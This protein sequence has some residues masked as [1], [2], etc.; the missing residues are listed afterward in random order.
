MKPGDR[1][2]DGGGG[3]AVQGSYGQGHRRAM[4]CACQCD[5]VAVGFWCRPEPRLVGYLVAF[6][7]NRTGPQR[8]VQAAVLSGIYRSYSSNLRLLSFDYRLQITW[9]IPDILQTIAGASS[10]ASLPPRYKGPSSYVEYR[11]QEEKGCRNEGT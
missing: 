5:Q 9:T 4:S 6:V 8:F 3:G 7:F 10:P 2:G 1:D 11:K